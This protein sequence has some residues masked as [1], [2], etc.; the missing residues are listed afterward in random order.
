MKMRKGYLSNGRRKS[1]T[2]GPKSPN[3]SL[4]E[5][6]TPSRT[7]LMLQR[8]GGIQEKRATRIT[9]TLDMNASIVHCI[10]LA[11]LQLVV[12]QEFWWV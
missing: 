12:L 4:V 7:I 3:A 1:A 9:K 8:E 10:I 11:A 5:L 2:N 6:Q